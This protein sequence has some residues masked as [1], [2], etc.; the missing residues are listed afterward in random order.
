MRFYQDFQSIKTY[1]ASPVA[2]LLVRNLISHIA[3]NAIESLAFHMWHA[4]SIKL[5]YRGKH[6]LT[7][8][9]LRESLH[10]PTYY[11]MPPLTITDL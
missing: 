3:F 9:A 1:G 7:L 10:K 8:I 6:P 5:N 2:L 11:I 4:L